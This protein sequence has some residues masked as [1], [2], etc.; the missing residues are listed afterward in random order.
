MNDI[1]DDLRRI[2]P[3]DEADEQRLR[4]NRAVLLQELTRRPAP[5]GRLALR[6][7]LV[8]TATAAVA[9][10]VTVLALNPAPAPAPMAVTESAPVP[11]SSPTP[12][13][14]PA[15]P[16]ATPAPTTQPAPPP[17]TVTGVLAQAAQAAA[18]SAVPTSGF[19]RVEV[20]ETALTQEGHTEDGTSLGD[21]ADPEY[22]DVATLDTVR[23]NL[24]LPMEGDGTWIR[25]VAGTPTRE[26]LW[27][28]IDRAT[29]V[30]DF[31]NSI[32]Q[33]SSYLPNWAY[34]V[35]RPSRFADL[36]RDPQALLDLITQE[37]GDD[38]GWVILHTLCMGYA[39]ADLQAALFEAA[40]LLPDAEL[41]ES[42]AGTAVIEWREPTPEPGKRFRLTIDTET[43]QVVASDWWWGRAS[44]LLG[45][46]DDIP[47]LHRELSGTFVDSAPD[48]AY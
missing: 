25:Q 43:G 32:G 36:P 16:T 6:V 12:T 5:R 20:T 19:R 30:P 9:G 24:Y 3:S 40:R 14:P 28:R 10:T 34:Y 46:P 39:P 44:L 48:T 41:L 1:L 7:G 38:A 45:T 13:D 22:V 47:D 18:S 23:W 4:R 21:L 42:S 27:G 11:I 33:A 17:P 15:Q 37:R 29:P 35:L 8:A 2:L 26:A 31:S